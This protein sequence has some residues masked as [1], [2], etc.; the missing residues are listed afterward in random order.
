SRCRRSLTPT[1]T[2]SPR[3]SPTLFRS[4]GP[5]EYLPP[6]REIF[7]EAL[8]V[9]TF[10]DNERLDAF[11][12]ALFTL[13]GPRINNVVRPIGT[14]VSELDEHRKS[15]RLNSRSVKITYALVGVNK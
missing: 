10:A 14:G 11:Q 3:P 4:L 1:P 8:P 9:E 2:S 15:T 5:V 13:P 7:G 12:A 6:A